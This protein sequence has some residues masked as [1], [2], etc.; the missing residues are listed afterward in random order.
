MKRQILIITDHS[1][2]IVDP[3]THALK[4][5]VPLAAVE[6]LCLSELSDN[7]FAVIVPTEYDLLMATTR[8]TEIVKVLVESMKTTSNYEL[9]VHVSNRYFN[10]VF[11]IMQI[12]H[13]FWFFV[14]CYLFKLF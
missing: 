3:E 4:R 6:K 14:I 10:T 5:R 13:F 9:E 8:K 7:F 1:I 11:Y 12:M 2:Y